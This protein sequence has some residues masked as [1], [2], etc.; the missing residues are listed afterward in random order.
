MV[1]YGKC[2]C[3]LTPSSPCRILLVPWYSLKMKP[4]SVLD[5]LHTILRT[6]ECVIATN[7]GLK[8]LNDLALAS[9]ED[10]SN[11]YYVM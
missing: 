8:T 11:V 10:Q 1:A 5:Y 3:G 2:K 6:D 9:R 4:I 7:I